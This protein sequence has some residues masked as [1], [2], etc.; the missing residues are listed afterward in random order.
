MEEKLRLNDP[1]CISIPV[2]E[3]SEAMINALDVE[4]IFL[5]SQTKVKSENIQGDSKNPLVRATVKEM[6]RSIIK[7]LPLEYGI[8]LV[9]SYRKY[10]F[11]RSLFQKRFERLIKEEAL[12]R[13]VA[14]EKAT[15]FV[16]NPDIYSPHVTGGAI[17]IGLIYLKSG[18]LLD[19]GNNFIY[20]ESAET[21]YPNLTDS[22]KENRKLLSRTM[23]SVGFVN[24]PFEWWHWSYGDKYWAYVKEESFAVY[25]SLKDI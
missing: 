7:A 4:R 5:L 15:Q 9:E 1:R 22:Q 18:E 24:Y 16:S 13:E 25:D 21:A 11:Q 6:L 8:L 12:S 14:I 2:K 23:E 20:D 10:E 3:N 17:D 19:M